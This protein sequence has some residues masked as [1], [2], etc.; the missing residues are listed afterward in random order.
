MGFLGQLLK[1]HLHRSD[2]CAIYVKTDCGTLCVQITTICCTIFSDYI[3]PAD[4]LRS[5]AMMEV[6]LRRKMPSLASS[7][8]PDSPALTKTKNRK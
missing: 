5:N 2:F 6:I 3:I 8:P 7:A 1:I 4:W